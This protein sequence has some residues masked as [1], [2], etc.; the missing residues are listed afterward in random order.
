MKILESQKKESQ[1][2]QITVQRMEQGEAWRKEE[3]EKERATSE[4]RE[5]L[6][7]ES[8]ETYRGMLSQAWVDGQPTKEE[9]SM[10]EVVRLS[11]G[12]EESDHAIVEREV[13][14]DAYTE[15]LQ[16]AWRS[17]VLT[18]EDTRASENLRQLYGVS[19]DEHLLIEANV[20]K[21]MSGGSSSSPSCAP[22]PPAGFPL[23]CAIIP[24]FVRKR[25]IERSSLTC[26]N[27]EP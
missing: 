16:A 21:S 14:V 24:S 11:L 10:L 7:R 13:Q 9:Q 20:R 6:K 5:R 17:G 1:L 22:L 2:R 18:A 27:P 26:R 12:I 15:A 4:G 3:E 19:T 23:L 25:Y 8:V